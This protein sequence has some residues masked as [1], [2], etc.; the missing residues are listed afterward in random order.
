MSVAQTE[1]V[2]ESLRPLTSPSSRSF[3]YS[4]AQVAILLGTHCGANFLAEQLDSIA[5]QSCKNVRIWASDDDSDDGT[6]DLLAQYQSSWEEGRITILPGPKQGFVANFL[7]LLYNPNIQASYFAFCDQDDLW[8]TD[9]LTKALAALNDVT[10]DIPAL[11]CSRTK[12]VD[13]KGR[14]LELS[15]LF[16]KS[17]GF[18]NALV[19][20]VGGGNTMVMNKAARDLLCKAGI[21]DV[22]S[23]DW[24]C[25]QLISGAGGTVIYDPRPSILYRQHANN[26]V[27]SNSSWLAR[28]KRI[29]LLLQGRFRVWNTVN[30]KAL[31]EAED[32]L[33]DENR[34]TLKAFGLARERCLVPRI[35]GIWQSGIYRQTLLGNLGLIAATLLKKL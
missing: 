6:Q 29:R 34:H 31:T 33:T 4:P 20:N 25:Y 15:P 10:H 26:H 17:P 1:I 5:G 13:E 19:Q 16:Q 7:S 28:L 8:E 35:W 32:L 30:I 3:K 2:S 22:V 24:W 12:I 23:H 18:S 14:P 21:K 27:G 11:Y 9:K